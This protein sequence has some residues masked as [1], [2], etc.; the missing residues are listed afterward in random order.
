MLIYGYITIQILFLVTATSSSR[1]TVLTRRSSSISLSPTSARINTFTDITCISD[2]DY[3]FT[4]LRTTQSRREMALSVR[5]GFVGSKNNPSPPSST[6]LQQKKIKNG[7]QF[8]VSSII[9]YGIWN[10]RTTLKNIFDKQN[11]QDYTVETLQK[12]NDLPYIYS[13]LFY[14]ISMAFWE[15]LGMS[16]IPV[17]TAAGMVFGWSGFYWSAIGKLLG[18]CL[19]FGLGRGALSTMV[20]NKLSSNTFL[21]LVQSSTEENPFLVLILMKLSCFPET[22]KNFGSS[23]LKPIKWWMFIIGT[24][25][26]GWTF[27]LLWTYLGVDSAA[28]IIDTSNSLPSDPILQ[29]LLSLALFNGFVVS[30]LSMAYWMRTLKKKNNQQTTAPVNKRRINGFKRN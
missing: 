1:R 27:T 5:G 26:H 28:R 15:A 7:F 12:L 30:P 19:A 3:L 20:N 29:T 23:V 16:T 25:A 21:Q 22:V 2:S 10:Y 24:A 13:R 17:E 6:A 9:L 18:A 11:L 4:D 14:T 8:L